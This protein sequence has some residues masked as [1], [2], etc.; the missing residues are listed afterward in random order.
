MNPESVYQTTTVRSFD[1]TRK[2]LEEKAGLEGFRVLKV[3]DL[4]AALAEKGFP[5]EPASVVEVCNAGLA[6]EALKLDPLAALLMPCRVVVQERNGEVFLSAILPESMVE[7]EALKSLARQAGTKL[8]S[9]ID[10]A[11]SLPSCCRI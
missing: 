11:A 5:I 7:G 3:H 4:K 9:L 2:R 1:E 8:V 6:S 10:T